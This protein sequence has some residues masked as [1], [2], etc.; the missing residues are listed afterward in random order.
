ML[1]CEVN[2][3]IYDKRFFIKCK[4]EHTLLQKPAAFM[5]FL[6][7]AVDGKKFALVVWKV[8]VTPLKNVVRVTGKHFPSLPCSQS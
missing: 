5:H 1:F 3:G 4:F 7:A 6:F 2:L 8:S